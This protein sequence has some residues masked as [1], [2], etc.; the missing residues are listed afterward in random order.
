MQYI[1]GGIVAVVLGFALIAWSDGAFCHSDLCKAQWQMR[2]AR[3]AAPV[4]PIVVSPRPTI[5]VPPAPSDGVM[6]AGNRRHHERRASESRQAPPPVPP[7]WNRWTD[8]GIC[9][10]CPSGAFR[11][12]IASTPGNPHGECNC[13]Y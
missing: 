7:G 4:A 11:R 1:V 8:S 9:K 2:I 12:P 5:T 10:P 13:S 6:V 3:E